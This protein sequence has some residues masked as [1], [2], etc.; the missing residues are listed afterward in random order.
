MAAYT[1]G[2][3]AWTRVDSEMHAAERRSSETTAVVLVEIQQSRQSKR[4]RARGA[5][6]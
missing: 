2:D 5:W 6:G 3:V 4:D 1:R